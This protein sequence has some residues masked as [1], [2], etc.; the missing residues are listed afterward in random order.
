[1]EPV[2]MRQHRF[3]ALLTAA[4]AVAL[5]YLFATAPAPLEG[6]P[7]A[8]PTL[9]TAEALTLLAHENDVT[10]TLFTKAIVGQGKPQGLKFSEHWADPM[11]IAGPLPALF[12]RG[13]AA[14]L[15][16]SD[17]PLGL[18][19]GSDFPIEASNKF[20]GRQAEE[21]AAMRESPAPRIFQDDASGDL[22]GMFPDYASAPA[23]V[24]CH[25]DHKGSAKHDWALNDLMGATTWSYPK[26]SVTT[27][28]FLSMLRAYRE[29]VAAVWTAY[30][31]KV[32]QIPAENRP[33]VGSDWPADGFFLPNLA[34]L[35]DS[36]D[37][38]AAPTLIQGVTRLA[39]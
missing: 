11:V 13:V 39:S 2:I 7:A 26:D 24:N 15:A 18:F 4:T 12:L 35:R 30:L 20:K 10:R 21:F 3:W 32:D 34:T 25:N 14:H 5:T 27:D 9:S 38:L 17:V 36:L 6:A 23:C 19:L 29:G 37:Q 22:I 28:E 31:A 16:K 33:R 8:R 1:M